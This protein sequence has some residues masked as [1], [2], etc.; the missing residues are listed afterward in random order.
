MSAP[1][2]KKL[3][4]NILSMG[5]VTSASILLTFPA[6]ALINPGSSNF[7]QN[8]STSADSTVINRSLLAQST[9]GQQ[10]PNNGGATPGTG[11]PNNGGASRINRQSPRVAGAYN[12]YMRI[13]YAATQKRDYQTALINF[14]RALNE[15]PGDSYATRAISNVQSYIQRSRQ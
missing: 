6:L 8:I 1:H 10:Q 12:R 3:I 5:G 9:S 15:R 13:G 11:Q 7:H 2:S 4:K 14:R